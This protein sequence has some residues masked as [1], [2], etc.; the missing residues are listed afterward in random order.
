MTNPP[1]PPDE[2]MK[3]FERL[4]ANLYDAYLEEIRKRHELERQ[5]SRLLLEIGDARA[6][7]HPGY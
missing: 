4:L 7:L 2:A 5:K 6:K 1:T 3:E